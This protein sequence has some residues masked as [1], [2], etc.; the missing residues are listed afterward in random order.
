ML[1]F[2]K[3]VFLVITFGSCFFAGCCAYV[4]WWAMA[5]EVLNTLLPPG[6]L[7]PLDP[8]LAAGS[9]KVVTNLT[10]TN[11]LLAVVYAALILLI[12]VVDGLLTGLEERLQEQAKLP[13]LSVVQ[14]FQTN[15][16]VNAVASAGTAEKWRKKLPAA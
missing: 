3:Y 7:G 8:F 1:N 4:Y 5:G 14:H 6:F 11:I 12:T 16:Y 13:P 15:N 9:Y 10:M 2:S